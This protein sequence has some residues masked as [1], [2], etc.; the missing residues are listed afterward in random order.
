[1]TDIALILDAIGQLDDSEIDLADAALQLARSTAPD[2][3]L[4]ECRAHLSLM[5][6]AAAALAGDLDILDLPGCAAMLSSL[7][8]EEFGY[9]GDS[10]TYDDLANA[11][12]IRVIE[13]RKGLPVALGI[14]WLHAARATGW[15]AFGINFPGHFLVGLG[16]GNHQVVL[17]VFDGGR[18]MSIEDLRKILRRVHGK[19]VALRREMLAPMTNR[20][21]LLRLHGNIRS[22]QES[23]GQ[24]HDALLTL[25]DMLRIAP[26]EPHLWL[27]AAVLHK[28]HDEIA[29]TLDCYDRFLAL[30]PEGA[31]AD[32]IKDDAREL[33]GRMN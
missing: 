17:D 11:N 26:E 20:E 24:S 33:R 18:I 7:L 15:E 2:A 5:A 27:E 31:A 25:R 4:H 32:R 29:A 1:M 16:A 14:I 21:I 28:Q 9:R 19:R 13:R 12:L 30:V 22:R 3:D 23:R 10:E 8:A 6:R